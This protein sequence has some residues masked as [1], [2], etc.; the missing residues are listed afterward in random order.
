[1]IVPKL[2]TVSSL[3]KFQSFNYTYIYKDIVFTRFLLTW[4]FFGNTH[5]CSVSR[6][7]MEGGSFLISNY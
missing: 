5:P 7:H 3:Q 4:V 1:M 6:V 2:I